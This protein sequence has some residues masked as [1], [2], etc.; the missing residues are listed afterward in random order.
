MDT[1]WLHS[2]KTC[3]PL[4]YKEKYGNTSGQFSFTEKKHINEQ[5]WKKL[6]DKKNRAFIKKYHEDRNKI[7]SIKIYLNDS[8]KESLTTVKE[9][10]L[11]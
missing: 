9:Q 7:I 1:I 10:T 3:H 6:N 11:Y 4:S 2:P 5:I 8:W